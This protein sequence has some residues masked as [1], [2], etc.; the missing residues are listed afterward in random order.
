MASLLPCNP[1][2]AVRALIGVALALTAVTFVVAALEAWIGVGDA[3]AAY[4]LAVVACALAYGSWAAV[5]VSVGSFLVYDLLFVDPRH[6]LTV[7]DPGE[8]LTLLVLLVTG[9]VVGQL[10][11]SARNRAHAA[12]A[13]E[14]EARA[15][16]R[17]SFALARRDTTIGVLPEVV[18]TLREATAMDRVWIVLGADDTGPVVA[19]TGSGPVP[20]PARQSILRRTQGDAPAEWV[21]VLVPT[22]VGA[23]RSR[24]VGFRARIEAAGR[25]LGVVAAVRERSLGTPDATAT[26]MLSAAADQV[27]Q[28][29]EQDRLAEEAREREIALQG[30][31]L[32]SALLESVSHDLRTPLASIRA[33]AGSLRD[34]EIPHPPEDTIAMGEAIDREAEYLNRLV[35]NL[36]DLSRIEAGTLR[37]D[38]EPYEPIDLIERTIE[39]VRPGFGDRR[40]EVAVTSALPPV[41]ADAVYIDQVLTNL[42]DNARKYAPPDRAIRVS[43]AENSEGGVVL[44]VEDGGQGVPPSELSRVFQ[45]F[46]RVASRSGSRPGTG[47]GLAVVRGLVEAMGGTV[48]ARR[49]RL[50]GL[51]IDISLRAAGSVRPAQPTAAVTT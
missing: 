18:A 13:R 31:A 20:S 6:T 38:L 33:A 49:S 19:D 44:T 47:I 26:R 51:A 24:Q 16:F 35:T 45:K 39:R 43:A 15:M 34:P 1:G 11:A 37:A 4:L 32:K 30:D 7:N 21:D 10:A 22:P 5:V 14:R 28:A 12:E 42:L 8:W 27:G 41:L 2:S 17:V 9:I 40:I 48:S 36:L 46:Y 25:I 50:G 29:L 3:S 23:N